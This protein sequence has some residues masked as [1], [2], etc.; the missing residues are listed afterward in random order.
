MLYK[1]VD[2]QEFHFI[3]FQITNY[4]DKLRFTTGI[5]VGGDSGQLVAQQLSV[6]TDGSD[7]AS[8]RLT[9]T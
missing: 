6:V 4:V 1:Q 8:K 9:K 2:E 7:F 5:C 3:S